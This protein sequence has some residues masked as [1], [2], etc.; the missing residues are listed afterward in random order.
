VLNMHYGDTK[1]E[2]VSER[3]PQFRNIHFSNITAEANQ[4]GL[5][6]GLDEMHIDGIT[7]NNINIK[8]KKGFEIKDADHIEFHN[9]QV[10]TESGPS[11]T[12]EDVNFLEI[13]GL[14]TLMPHKDTPVV[15]LKNVTD[16]YVHSNF[17]APD[18][19]IFL[20]LEGERTENIVLGGNNFHHVENIVK[21]EK[22]VSGKVDNRD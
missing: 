2:P 10:E 18:T 5:L 6:V 22:N 21:K 19:D 3:T 14:K 11:L 20:K 13:D 4:A 15:K 12:A 17:A 1:P 8:A 7:F 9:V 16:A